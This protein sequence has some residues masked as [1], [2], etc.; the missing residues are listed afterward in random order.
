M[1][2]PRVSIIIPTYR[3]PELLVRALGS[4]VD[5]TYDTWEAIVVDDNDATSPARPATETLMQRFA[6]EPRIRYLRHE[7]NRGLPAARNTG[8]EAAS[9]AF[10]AFLDDDDAW[11]SEKLEAQVAIMD[12]SDDVGL[13]FTGRRVVDGDGQLIRTAS[14][15][16]RSVKYDALLEENLIGTPSSVLVRR[17]VLV[18]AGGFD[19]RFPS[20]EDWDFY[21]RVAPL[22]ALAFVERP[23]TVYYQHGDGRMMDDHRTLAR[24]YALLY[25]KHGAAIGARPAVH[26]GFLRRYA[27]TLLRAGDRARARSV[28]W[29]AW[30]AKPLDRRGPQSLLATVLGDGAIDAVRRSTGPLRSRLRRRRVPSG[31]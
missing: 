20:L 27:R 5:Q 12:R 18:E 30:R 21:L 15:I 9:G 11:L 7:H 17:D 22:A 26:A 6:T 16:A 31:P 14:P 25:E 24:A 1:Q 19:E 2:A 23:L 28:A 4:V 10:V 13:V 3:R 8:I 29:R